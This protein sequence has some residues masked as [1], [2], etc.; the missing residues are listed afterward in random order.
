MIDEPVLAVANR[1]R[2]G[3]RADD[4]VRMLSTW[5]PN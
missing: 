2:D 5:I 4:R 3:E 1:A